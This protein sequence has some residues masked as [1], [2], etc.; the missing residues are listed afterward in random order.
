MEALPGFVPTSEALSMINGASLRLLAAI[1]CT[2][3]EKLLQS[4]ENILAMTM[5]AIFAQSGCI[6][7]K[8]LEARGHKGGTKVATRLSALLEGSS[9]VVANRD[10]DAFSIRCAP[11][12]LGAAYDN[13]EH[14]KNVVNT[15]LNGAC[16]NPLVIEGQLIEAGNF[17]GAPIGQA[18]DQLKSR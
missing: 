16:D 4:S 10:P 15:E 9:M 18:M 12:V 5:E 14:A 11:S 6:N 2:R 17:H 13:L 3:A 8:A 1:A 7:P